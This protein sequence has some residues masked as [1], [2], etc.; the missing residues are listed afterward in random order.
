[1]RSAA[2]RGSTPAGLPQGSAA[3]VL[4]AGA[5]QVLGVGAGGI[6]ATQSSFVGAE[7]GAGAGAA[8]EPWAGEDGGGDPHGSSDEGCAGAAFGGAVQRSADTFGSGGVPQ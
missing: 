6:G 5:D 7:E 2:V 3:P 4:A 8:H 1:M